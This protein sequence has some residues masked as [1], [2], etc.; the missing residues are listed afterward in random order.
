MLLPAAFTGFSEVVLELVGSRDAIYV[1]LVIGRE[2]VKPSS[3]AGEQNL[4]NQSQSARVQVAVNGV[5]PNNEG[6]AVV[7]GAPLTYKLWLNE[8]QK[9]VSTKQ[10]FVVEEVDG[11]GRVVVPKNV[12]VGAKPLW[13]DFVIGK[14]L[15]NKA[16][17]VGKIHMIVNK[18]WIPNI[19]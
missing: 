5:V 3:E 7:V 1:V 15:N 17:H 9:H 6:L 2:R 8:A 19:E 12:F 18:I 4:G 11:Q 14:F 16:P 13:E 10:K